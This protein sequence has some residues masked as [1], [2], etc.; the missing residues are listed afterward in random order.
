MGFEKLFRYAPSGSARRVNYLLFILMIILNMVGWLWVYQHEGQ[1]MTSIVLMGAISIFSVLC[2]AGWIIARKRAREDEES[3]KASERN[4]RQIFDSVNEAIFIH[5]MET[6]DILDVNQTMCEMYGYSHDEAVCLKVE[7]YSQGKTPYTQK[8]AEKW[9]RKAVDE[10]PHTFE[11]L[12]KRKNG[13]MFWLEVNLKRAVIGGEDRIIAVVRD[14]SERKQAGKRLAHQRRF[15]DSLIDHSALAIVTLDEKHHIITCNRDFERLFGFKEHEITGKN[16]DQVIGRQKH[17]EEAGSYTEKTL[18]GD[19]IHGAGK[20]YRKDGSE[21]DVDFY[22]IPVIVEGKVVGAFGI[23]NDITERRQAEEALRESEERFRV[24]FQ[25]TPDSITITRTKDGKYLYLNDGFCQITGYSREEAIGKTPF[26]LN[27]IVNPADRDEFVRILKEE[28]EVSGFELQYRMKDGTIFDT[29]FSARPI[30]YGDEECLVAIVKDITSIKRTEQ[31]KVMLEKQLQHAQKMEAIG[32]L[33]GGISHDFNNLLQAIMGYT[34]ML[35]LD[36][37][38]EDPEFERLSAIEKAANRA[39]ELTQQLLTFSRKVESKLRPVNLNQEVRQVEK[40]LKRTIPR[41]IDIKLHLDE[42]IRIINA[43]PAQVEQVLM[44]LGVNARDAMPEGGEIIVE[45]ENIILDEEYCKT[46]L[47]AIAGE[48]VL[49][50]VSDTGYGM[51]KETVEHIFEP[52][53]TTKKIGKGTGLGLAMVYGIVKNHG[54]YIM[55]YS[56]PGEGTTFKIY[57]P[58][59]KSESVEQE[60]GPKTEEISG[61]HET[62][63]LVDDEEGI[64]DIGKGMLERFGYT[65]IIAESGEKAIEIY[66]A[67]KD[68]IDLVVLD[69]SMPGMGGHKCLSELREIDPRIK[70]II[71]SGYAASGKVKETLECGAAAFIGKPYQLADMLK[72]VREVL[73]NLREMEV[74]DEN[75]HELPFK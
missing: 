70:V 20:R 30:Q 75:N 1:I 24:T 50:S 66:K 10:G 37:E 57:F 18:R 56:E 51:D 13:E 46:H 26:D 68:R 65:A 54:G 74:T 40:L 42:N 7:D 14:V 29:L 15:L 2:L 60:S 67:E 59:I 34:Q 21:V 28:G 41:M 12:G 72:K 62:V 48:Y 61:G 55:C 36:K 25:S 4:Y 27:L 73:D 43:D 22:G 52:F 17:L 44:N 9:M 3:L 38:R 45:T 63:L 5:D 11:W 69:L 53:F 23:Y 33:A 19:P 39:S 35:L 47:G 8:D 64:L 31:E 32:T 71:A 16:L 6:G 49:L 58:A